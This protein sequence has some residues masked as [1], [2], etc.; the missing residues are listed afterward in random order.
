MASKRNSRKTRL[1]TSEALSIIEQSCR[2]GTPEYPGDTPTHLSLND[3]ATM[4][5]VFQG[6]ELDGRYN[7]G[8]KH[9]KT[10]ANAIGK[11]PKENPKFLDPILVWWGGDRFYVVDGHHRRQAYLET[12]VTAKV[13]VEVFEGTLDEAIARAATA[14]SKDRL[15]MTAPEKSTMAWRMVLRGKLKS[16]EIEAASGVSR[17]QVTIMR[18]ALRVI[19]E[20]DR[21]TTRE[22]LMDIPWRKALKLF[23]HGPNETDFASRDHDAEAEKRAQ[24]YRERLFKSFGSKPSQD[25]TAFAMALYKADKGIP[26]KYADTDVWQEALKESVFEAAQDALS[27]MIR[28]EQQRS[29]G[30]SGI[31]YGRLHALANLPHVFWENRADGEYPL[32]LEEEPEGH[33]NEPSDY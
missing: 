32:G 29:L 22:E 26:G 14:N 18:K 7:E 12:R 24:E 28:M 6:R 4:V 9:I 20:R 13:P 15:P 21:G 3:M 1:K 17:A 11:N 19:L 27:E 31:A 5:G 10:L 30:S 23:K 33:P 25:Y 2:E 16:R 8:R